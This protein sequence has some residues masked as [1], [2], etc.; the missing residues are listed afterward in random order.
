MS[1]ATTAY[2]KCLINNCPGAD[3]A[4]TMM[5]KDGD[6]CQDVADFCPTVNECCP[7][8]QTSLEA[9]L[10]C[11]TGDICKAFDCAA[12]T[13]ADTTPPDTSGGA[14][15]CCT[16][17]ETSCPEGLVN[18][19]RSKYHSSVYVIMRIPSFHIVLTNV[20]FYCLPAI[21]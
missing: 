8:C 17:T 18:V 12:G 13:V 14:S 5:A 9:L 1:E 19:G 21:I 7:A 3:A 16:T 20:P 4:C 11:S 2:T 6:T 10:D 15:D